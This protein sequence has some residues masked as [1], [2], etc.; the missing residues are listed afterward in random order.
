MPNHIDVDLLDKIDSE[1]SEK[2]LIIAVDFRITHSSV[3][4]VEIPEGCPSDSGRKVVH[5][6]LHVVADYLTYL[7]DDIESDLR[8]LGY[9]DSCPNEMVLCIPATWTQQ[10]CRDMQK[11]LVV[12]MKR[13]NF[14][15]VNIQNNSIEN[16][17][18]YRGSRAGLIRAHDEAPHVNRNLSLITGW[19]QVSM[20]RIPG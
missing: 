3:F 6:P 2:R 12:A 11:W 5:G 8:Q 16:L 20:V 19:Q 15:G 4:Y 14:K 18:E 7:L 10:A 1:P 9:D 17:Y 13:A